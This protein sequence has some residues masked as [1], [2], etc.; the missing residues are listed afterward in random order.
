M[1]G[2]E[3]MKNEG[4]T[5]NQR[6]LPGLRHLAVLGLMMLVSAGAA[7]AQDSEKRLK[8]GGDLQQ[9]KLV[10]DVRPVYP[11]LAKRGH[12][13]GVVRLQATIGKDGSVDKVE[14]VSGHP[15]LQQAAIDAVRQWRY[16]PTT[17]NGE[18]V[19]VVTTIDVV[20]KIT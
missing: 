15:V 1:K 9:A 14:P 3:E 19:E 8:V 11:V 17:L 10:R 16:K 13:E 7:M 4:Q 18:A 2:K 6:T 5:K 12:I 20:F